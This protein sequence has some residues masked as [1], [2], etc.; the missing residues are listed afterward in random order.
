MDREAWWATVHEVAKSRIRLTDIVNDNN[1]K[2]TNKDQQIYQG[3]K[4]MN[5]LDQDTQ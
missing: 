4:N 5:E 3:E 1:N 2:G